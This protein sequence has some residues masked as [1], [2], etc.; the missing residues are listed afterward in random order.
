MC[1]DIIFPEFDGAVLAQGRDP[2][3]TEKVILTYFLLGDAEPQIKKLEP[4]FLVIRA[5]DEPDLR[6]P[7][8]FITRG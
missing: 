7:D 2:R 6:R 4:A 8:I 1:R 3:E 5:F